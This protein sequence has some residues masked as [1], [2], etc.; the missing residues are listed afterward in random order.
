VG[1]I[2]SQTRTIIVSYKNNNFSL[3]FYVYSH[4][5]LITIILSSYGNSPIAFNIFRLQHV[6]NGVLKIKFVTAA[7]QSS[8]WKKKWEFLD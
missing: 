2:A 6:H 1:H 7:V 5:T 8:W 3:F 4:P